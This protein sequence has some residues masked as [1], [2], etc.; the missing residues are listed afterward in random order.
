MNHNSLPVHTLHTLLSGYFVIFVRA[1]QANQGTNEVYLWPELRLYLAQI[2]CLP[3]WMRPIAESCI[4]FRTT[5]A[6]CTP[7]MLANSLFIISKDCACIGIR[8]DIF[9]ILETLSM[10][11]KHCLGLHIDLDFVRYIASVAAQAGSR[12]ICGAILFFT[13]KIYAAQQLWLCW[14]H[15]PVT[16]AKSS[17]LCCGHQCVV[18]D[19]F[20]WR[21]IV[22]HTRYYIMHQHHFCYYFLMLHCTD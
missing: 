6:D 17:V 18:I 16:P 13:L 4:A 22:F 1:F 2:L 7:G 15:T 5:T 11:S 19:V 12:G 3:C 21:Y 14:S 8:G 10:A 9:F 20:L